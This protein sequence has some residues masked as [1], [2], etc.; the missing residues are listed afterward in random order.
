M[1]RLLAAL[2]LA[3]AAAAAGCGESQ[4]SSP[5]TDP[6]SVKKLEEQQRKASQGER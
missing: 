2:V 4:P 5:A 3:L 1:T 6:D